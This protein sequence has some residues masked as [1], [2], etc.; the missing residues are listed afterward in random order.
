MLYPF[1]DKQAKS[2][3]GQKDCFTNPLFP[4]NNLPVLGSVS[5]NSIVLMGSG[6]RLEIT[7]FTIRSE[8]SKL[9]DLAKANL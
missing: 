9:F 8:V 2:L 6:K 4:R 3:T 5:G 1:F 7:D